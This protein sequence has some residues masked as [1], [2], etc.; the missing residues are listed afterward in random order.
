MSR[1][2]T[3]S[4]YPNIV[5]SG[6]YTPTLTNVTNI[7]SNTSYQCQ[8]IR[9]GNV[10]TV[11]G[12]VSITATATGSV[13]LGISLPVASNIGG[14][15]TCAGTSNNASGAYPGSVYGDGTNKRAQVNIANHP[16]SS[17]LHYFSFTY[18][19]I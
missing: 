14:S 3:L 13:Q 12:A 4:T 7:S 6:T 19:V 18:Q 5:V 16:T 10:V 17:L 9:V 2:Q 11:S 1:A 15:N 8:Y